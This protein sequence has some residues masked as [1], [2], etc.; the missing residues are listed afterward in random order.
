MAATAASAQHIYEMERISSTDLNGTARFVGMGGAMNALGAE[1]STISTNPAGIGLY[2]KSDMALTGSI[3]IQKGAPDFAGIGKTRASFDQAGVAVA[4]KIGGKS[5]KYINYGFSYLKRKN[6]KNFIGL[7]N[8]LTG[9]L[10]QS[11]QMLDL[12]WDDVNGHWHDLVTEEGRDLAP[13]PAL[14]GYETYRINPDGRGGYEPTDAASYN[15]RRVQWGGVHDYDF[16]LS[17]NWFDQI[18][19][20]A[21]LGVHSVDLHSALDYGEML[22]AGGDYYFRHDQTLTGS[23]IDAKFGLIVRP[24]EENPFRIGLAFHTPTLYSVVSDAY[25]YAD[26]PNLDLLDGSYA[27]SEAE[28]YGREYKIRTP[29]KVNVSLGTTAGTFFAVDAEYEYSNLPTARTIY[30]DAYWGGRQTDSGLAEEAE[31]C[32]RGVHTFRVGAEAR[33]SSNIFVRAGYNF[34]SAPMKTD[35]FLNY[36]ADSPSYYYNMGTDYVNL[37]ATHRATLGLGYRGKHFYVDAAYQYQTQAADVYAFHAPEA[38]NNWKNRLQG[39]GI[40]LKRSNL[41]LTLGY[42]F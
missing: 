28:V 27:S 10:S 12:A 9:G 23:G 4:T 31:A 19:A 36:F 34:V 33:V 29:W 26:G 8:V 20:G 37:G 2:R 11:Y 15:Y 41:M 35:A 13:Y 16:N 32:L 6:L 18:Y 21:T 42:K 1:L 22:A 39:Q 38:G 5:L 30:A 3:T 40:D 14:M 25:A 24:V 7:D 17:F